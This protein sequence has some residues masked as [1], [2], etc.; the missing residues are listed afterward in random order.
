MFAGIIQ[1]QSIVVS[2]TLRGGIRLVAIQRPKGWRLAL[3]QSISVNG[4]CSTVAAIQGKTF[5]VE[6][7][8]ETLALTTA[9]AFARGTAVNLERSL[10]LKDLID[11]HVVMGH[12]DSKGEVRKVEGERI[13]IA[14]PKSLLRFMPVKGSVAINGVA[15][16]ITSAGATDFSIAL[17]PYTTEHTNLGKLKV[18]YEVNV[19][20]DMI[21][22]YLD[23][24]TKS[25]KKE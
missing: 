7:M 19:E 5:D 6:Y 4:I 20:I 21:A 1:A 16:T 15:L 14:V 12:V 25:R 11:G 10:A 22:R 24:L 23:T 9:F 8:S 18:G 2:A 17:I 3:G 13:T